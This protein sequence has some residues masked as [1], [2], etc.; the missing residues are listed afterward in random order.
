MPAAGR[1][2]DLGCGGGHVSVEL[3]R[4][5]G[6][7]GSVLGIDLDPEIV[8]LARSAAAARGIGN[9]EFRVG[10][11]EA[12]DGGPF[13]LTYARFLLS[14]VADPAS[15]VSAMA[16]A[17]APGGLV[18]VEDIDFVG[19]FCYPPNAAYRRSVQ[20]YLEVVR[21]RGGNAEI[22][23]ALPAC[24]SGR[25]WNACRSRGCSRPRCRARP[26]R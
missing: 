17:L 22:G 25:A 16:G 7:D 3:A 6:P 18:V 9:I 15:V 13:D 1:V 8:E 21:R 19:S 2:L 23:P 26:R 12:I 5:V 20:M 10:S 11:A 4:L 14:H 24:C